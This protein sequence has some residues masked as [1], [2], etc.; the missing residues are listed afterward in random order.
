MKDGKRKPMLAKKPTVV[1]A[2]GGA[3]AKG[4]AKDDT[5]PHCGRSLAAKG[6]VPPPAYEE[7][8]DEA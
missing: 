2:I 3:D 4:E 7:E 6:A 5:C 8:E 1:I